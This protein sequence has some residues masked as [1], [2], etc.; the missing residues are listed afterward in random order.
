VP[1]KLLHYLPF[2]ALV[3]GTTGKPLL[4]DFRLEWSPSS[5]IFVDCSEQA[6]EDKHM[7]F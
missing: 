2:G 3:S 6:A 5:T 4:E 1:D 7:T